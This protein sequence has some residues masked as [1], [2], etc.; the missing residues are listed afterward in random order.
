MLNYKTNPHIQQYADDILDNK[1]PHCFELRLG[2]MKVIN[3]LEN[4]N[5]VIKHE[6]IDEAIK[7]IE[8][9]F[10]KLLPWE[11][12]VTALT[13]GCYKD[14][15]LLYNEMLLMLGRG[16]GKNGYIAGLSNYF[17][18]HKHGIF[19][20][21]IDIVATS[22]AQAETSFLDVYNMLDKKENEKIKK[23]FYN[24]TKE[25]IT[26]KKT[27]SYLHYN[28]SNAKTKDGLRSACVIFDEIH[29]YQ[30]TDTI[31]VF[32]SGLGKKPD[33]RVFYITTDGKV[34]EGVLDTFKEEALQILRGEIKNS[35]TLPLIWKMD[36]EEE[37]S[38]ENTDLWEKANPSIKYMP[39]LFDQIY[40]D[41]QKSQ[42]R[43]NMKIETYTKRF[44]LP[45]QDIR[46][47]VAEWDKIKATETE[48]ID[49]SFDGMSCIGGFD[50]ASVK[51]F[52]SAVIL[53]KKGKKVYLKHHTWICKKS[54]EYTEYKF[55]IDRA[56]S[57]GY[58]TICDTE[59][60]DPEAA[61]SWFIEQA[62]KYDLKT[63]CIDNYRAKFVKEI[64]DKLGIPYT[65]M[66]N[67]TF[68]HTKIFPMIEKLF[69]DELIKWGKDFMMRWYTNNVYVKSDKKDNKTY[70]KIEPVKRKTDGF[71]AF[72]HAFTEIDRLTETGDDYMLQCYSY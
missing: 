41:L 64:F 16:N 52:M 53:F 32:T 60:L 13:V 14:D 29:A 31:D 44:N 55:D 56:V 11:R 8:K 35:R 33:S 12:F 67:G 71:F 23:K 1:I 61:A 62:Q 68:T 34:R 72:I 24:V 27:K 42:T 15:K 26:F 4:E 43:P 6:K 40:S 18:T 5:V 48:S 50:Y 9:Y 25:D 21:N 70:E 3:D 28:T 47:V 19:E 66:R 17:Q 57:E 38:L 39:N 10:F 7:H 45:K 65:E 63:V 2:I 69:A 51:D 49:E 20:Y 30:T 59:T 37:V 22:E 46:T 36:S 58:A 54:L